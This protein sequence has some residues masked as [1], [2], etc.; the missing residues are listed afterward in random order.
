M[1][2]CEEFLRPLGNS[3]FLPSNPRVASLSGIWKSYP[4]LG[5]QFSGSNLG[6]VITE[7]EMIIVEAR[8]GAQ[9]KRGA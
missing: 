8:K 7:L 2:W 9:G 5:V 4:L 6:T 3:D 1:L